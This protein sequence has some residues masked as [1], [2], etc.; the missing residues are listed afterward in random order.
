MCEMI[1][2]VHHVCMYNLKLNHTC[3]RII[4]LVFCE[5]TGTHTMNIKLLFVIFY[6]VG[7]GEGVTCLMLTMLQASVHGM[8]VANSFAF[9]NKVQC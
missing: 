5:D 3:L 1:I 8:V 2:T 9:M 6:W 7:G 4:L